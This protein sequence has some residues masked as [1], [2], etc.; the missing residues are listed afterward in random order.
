MTD[1][2][3]D[4]STADRPRAYVARAG[5]VF[6]EF[7]ERSQDSGNVSWGVRVG[8][9]HYGAASSWRGS[10]A[11]RDVVATACDPDPSRRFA[12]VRDYVDAWR[13]SSGRA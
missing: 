11:M 1:L 7:N 6:A 3:R 12:S 9:A 5:V 4:A 2:L 13:V 8:D 10:S